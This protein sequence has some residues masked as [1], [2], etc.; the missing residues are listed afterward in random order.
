MKYN[1]YIKAVIILGAIAVLGFFVQIEY[2][3]IRPSRA[4]DLRD[5]IR[6]ENAVEDERGGVYLLTVTQQRATLF[7]AAYAYFHPHMDLNP[8]ERVIPM[9]MDETEYRQLLVENMAESQHLAQVVALRRAGYEVE[10]DS[11]GVEV[12]G[13]FDDAPAVG[14]LEEKD[15]IINVDGTPVFLATEVPL[16]VQDRIPGEEVTLTIVRGDQEKVLTVPTAAHPDDPVMPFLGI[17]IQTLPWEP[18]LPVE[19]FMDTGRIG[20]PSAGLM[21]VLEIMNQVLPGDI[22]GGYNIAGTGTIDLNENVGRIGGVAQKVVAAE[23]AGIDYF[24]IP[25]SNYE[26]A[27]KVAGDVTLVPVS[28]LDEVL[29]FLS[30]LESR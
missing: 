8:V 17:F 6:V 3:M 18:V 4:V 28:N 16:L 26:Q 12:V 24:F 27:R 2:F 20:G 21:F 25:E 23:K 7:L 19:I 15:K 30:R 5:L 29:D 1:R 13:F 9:D 10:I 14:Y 22:T 11:E